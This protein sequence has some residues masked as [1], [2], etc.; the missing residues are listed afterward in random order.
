MPSIFLDEADN[1]QIF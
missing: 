1:S